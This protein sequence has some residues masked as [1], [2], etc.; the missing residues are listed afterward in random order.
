LKSEPVEGSIPS[1]AAHITDPLMI[2]PFDLL[3]GFQPFPPVGPTLGMENSFPDLGEGGSDTPPG[4][5]FELSHAFTDMFYF[6]TGLTT[7]K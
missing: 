3:Y 5:K 2:T 1:V 6:Y 7:I 4:Y